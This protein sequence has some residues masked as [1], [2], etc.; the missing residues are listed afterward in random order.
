M[1]KRMKWREITEGVLALPATA[2]Y[3]LPA[4]IG[5]PITAISAPFAFF[6]EPGVALVLLLIFGLLLSALLGLAALWVSIF[7]GLQHRP[8]LLAGGLVL[9]IIG[10]GGFV[11][12]TFAN[13]RFDLAETW[14][15]N[16]AILW[17]LL[18]VIPVGVSRFVAT[19]RHSA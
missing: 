2:L 13:D 10:A 7:G 6:S 5:V 12:M 4:L 8:R 18:L 19:V 9:G 3:G 17:P 15:W 14:T 16:A 11:L 1:L